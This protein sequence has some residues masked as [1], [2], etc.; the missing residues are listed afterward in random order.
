MLSQDRIKDIIFD[1]DQLIS[2]EGNSAPYLLY[3]FARARSIVDKVGNVELSG[4]PVLSE[5]LELQFI[6]QMLRMDDALRRA[7][8]EHKPHI[9]STYLY[10]LCQTFNRFYGQLRVAEADDMAKRARLGLVSAFMHQ[11]KA[12]LSILGI[13]VI[14]RM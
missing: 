2:L 14:N 1:W 5:A 3:S 10:E 4:L 9:L 13:P 12:G 8:E 7:L 6:R 11:M